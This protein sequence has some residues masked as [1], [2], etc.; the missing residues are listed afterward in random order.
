MQ[1]KRREFLGT[2]VIG[3]S[4]AW[5]VGL[6]EAQVPT[7]Q[8]DSLNPVAEVPLGRD[9][10]VT[11]VGMGFGMRAWNRQSNLS[12][13]GL[14]HAERVIRHAYERGIR[15]F[16]HADL[17]GSHQFFARAL[18]D[19]PRESYVLSTKIWFH[20]QG[21]PEPD[22]PDADVAV[23]RFL[24]E[25][26]TDYIDLV[27][28]HCMMRP[29][30]PAQMKRQMEILER[31]KEQK[32]IRAHGVSI[33]GFTALEAVV[34]QPWVDVVHVRIN[35]FGE[36]MDA[37]ADR[38]V[39]VVEK[40]HAGGAGVIGMKIVGEGAFSNDKTK[41]DQSINFVLGLKCVDAMIV[42]FETEADVD[43]F[44]SRVEAALKAR[45]A[46]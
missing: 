31:L 13:R 25:L 43:D 10:R 41:L 5:A 17:Y 9:L 7:G 28:I 4:G 23:K 44:L 21:L 2:A 14:D 19:K 29:D 1:V 22:R 6:A 20:P 42:G 45:A 39:P 40:I 8:G 33:H 27:Q 35:P 37:S 46:S 11:R 12:R 24:K 38:V 26:G 15:F 34:G 16:D 30:W 36:K 32:L 3:V 18:K